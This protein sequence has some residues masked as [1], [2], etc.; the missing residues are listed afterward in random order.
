MSRKLKIS[1]SVR[2]TD[3][4]RITRI[5]WNEVCGEQLGYTMVLCRFTRR[6]ASAS[7]APFAASSEAT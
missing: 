5:C 6:I 4:G 2:S 1:T 7:S 3:S